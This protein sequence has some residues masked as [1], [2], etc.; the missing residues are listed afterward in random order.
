MSF[1]ERIPRKIIFVVLIVVVAI[2]L[3]R[4]FP[5]FVPIT[6][7]TEN[8]Y[9]VIEALEPDSVVLV[10]AEVGT[11]DI[12]A[13]PQLVAT[14]KQLKEKN[15]RII[16]YSFW[17]GS[18]LGFEWVLEDSGYT[19]LEYGKDYVHL[20][21][22]PGED[23]AL[24]AFCLD[25][26]STKQVDHYGNPTVDMPLFKEVN[27]INEVDLVIASGGGTPGPDNWARIAVIPYDTLAIVAV[28]GAFAAR[29]YDYMALGV[30]KGGLIAQ[31]GAVEYESLTGYAGRATAN[32]APLYFA[33]IIL[34]ILMIIGNAAYIYNIRIKG[35]K[36]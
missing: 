34:L 30:F 22:I 4:P 25:M 1:L 5:V 9:N 19:K 10:G 29:M 26:V 6:D 24:S 20:G 35:E 11:R 31:R 27:S 21:F 8:Y 16:T 17:A 14:L 28:P 32:Y 33:H 23:A 13:Y 2:P 3:L 18:A 7:H 36:Q 15:A 12:E